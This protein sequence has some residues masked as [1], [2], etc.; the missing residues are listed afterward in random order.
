MGHHTSLGKKRADLES[1][2]NFLELK[3]HKVI[4]MI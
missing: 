3:W 1:H 2:S 4:M